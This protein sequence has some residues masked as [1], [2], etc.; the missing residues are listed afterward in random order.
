M[1]QQLKADIFTQTSVDVIGTS[2]GFAGF[3]NVITFGRG[4]MSMVQ[5]IIERPDSAGTTPGRAYPGKRMAGR[6]RASAS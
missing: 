5:K 3:R 1:G 6:L 2:I 4:P